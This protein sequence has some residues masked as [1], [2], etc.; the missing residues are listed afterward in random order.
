MRRPPS[1]LLAPDDLSEVCPARKDS[2]VFRKRGD[3]RW[4]VLFRDVAKEWLQ[5]A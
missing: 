5:P 3:G 4:A 2:L 1:V